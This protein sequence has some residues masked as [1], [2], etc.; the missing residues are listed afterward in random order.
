MPPGINRK[1]CSPEYER[2]VILNKK[3]ESAR[4][5]RRL[6]LRTVHGEVEIAM[7]GKKKERR[8]NSV[9]KGIRND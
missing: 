4:I 9:Y 8:R 6:L 3:S 2:K 7:E 1:L 5:R